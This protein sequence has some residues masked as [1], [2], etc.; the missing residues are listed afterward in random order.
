MIIKNDYVKITTDKE[1]ILHNYIYNEYLKS[2]SQAQY[3]EDGDP[4]AE[5]QDELAT[6][7]YNKFLGQCM[8]KL[9]EPLEDYK[10]AKIDDFDVILY[11][12]N[13]NISGNNKSVSSIYIYDIL[14]GAYTIDRKLITNWTEYINKKVTAIGFSHQYSSDIMACIDTSNYSI[15]LND[16]DSFKIL[17]KDNITSNAICIGEDYPFHLAPVES[18]ELTQTDQPTQNLARIYSIGLGTIAGQ[19]SSEFIVGKNI[20][21]NVIDDTTFGFNLKSGINKTLFPNTNIYASNGKYPL[22][23]YYDREQHLRNGLYPSNLKYPLK[24]NYKYIIIKY[25]E[26]YMNTSHL[27]IYTDKYYTMNYQISLKGLF[28]IR[29]K[30]E[31]S[32]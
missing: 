22:A 16:I 20:D 29:N 30:I 10:N 18:F 17:R 11:Y 25:R 19:M 6:Y 9:D 8:L 3:Y 7:N 27:I 28:E 2:F 4:Y 24:S 31:R 32:E 23:K 12:S 26:Y 13:F 14:K 1:Y 21:I 5:Y 15:F